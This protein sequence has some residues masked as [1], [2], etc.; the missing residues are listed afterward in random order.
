[1]IVS[2]LGDL[3]HTSAMRPEH[4]YDCVQKLWDFEIDV[5]LGPD[6]VTWCYELGFETYNVGLLY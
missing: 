3:V 4:H 5:V 6:S 2:E 1:M